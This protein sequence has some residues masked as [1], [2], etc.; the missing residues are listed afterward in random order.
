MAL[1]KDFSEHLAGEF[2][3][4]CSVIYKRNSRII[5]KSDIHGARHFPWLRSVPSTLPTLTCGTPP[6]PVSQVLV[7][8]TDEALEIV[9]RLVRGSAQ[10]WDQASTHYTCKR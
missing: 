4:S 5:A 9:P 2:N 1:A 3:T 10:I 7:T 8:L 6:I